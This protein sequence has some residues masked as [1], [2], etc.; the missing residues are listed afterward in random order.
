MFHSNI[1]KRSTLRKYDKFVK[2]DVKKKLLIINNKYN[3]RNY[4]K[5]DST[6]KKIMEKQH[7]LMDSKDFEKLEQEIKEQKTINE[8]LMKD[9]EES[10]KRKK[11]NK[12]QDLFPGE[13]DIPSEA[14]ILKAG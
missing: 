14:Q 4:A 5:K 9:A 8:L 1:L 6:A 12:Y 10:A 7:K 11:K 2:K 3:I 13:E